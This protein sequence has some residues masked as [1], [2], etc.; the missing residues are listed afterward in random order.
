M[1]IAAAGIMLFISAL[2]LLFGMLIKYRKCYWLISGYNTASA[3]KKKNIDIEGLGIFMGNFCF[4]LAGIFLVG[5]ILNYLGFFYGFV[6]SIGSLFIIIPIVL[7]K[8]Q[9]YD[10]NT[11]TSEGK[12]KKSV[13]II[14][15]LFMLVIFLLPAGMIY[16]GAQEP[17]VNITSDAI[18][19][20]GMYGTSIKLEDISGISLVDEIPSVLRK[21]NG[22]DFGSILRGNFELQDKG[23]VRLFADIK[24]PPFIVIEGRELVII[25]LKDSFKTEELYT[26][27]KAAHD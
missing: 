3:E 2:L 5:T 13:I 21:T 8:A 4:L 22:F 12:T 18:T 27:L 9:K 25:N 20:S 15:C 7:I 19:F 24:K 26:K 11:Q 14:I 10:K 17:E 16:Y 23:K 1:P 6:V